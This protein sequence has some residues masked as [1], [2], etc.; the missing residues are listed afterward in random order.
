MES[1]K[2]KEFERLCIY[3]M[4]GAE[5]VGDA[6]MSRYGVQAS[7]QNNEWRPIESLPDFE[8]ILQGGRQFVFDCKVC[9]QASFPLDDD[10]FKRRQLKHLLRRAKFGG[11]T[12][13]LIH[14]NQRE[15]K[16]RTDEAR[17]V[18]FPLCGHHAGNFWVR[19][20][21]G[22][23]KRITRDACDEY[24]IDVDWT[25][26]AGKERPNL[27]AAILRLQLLIRKED[28]PF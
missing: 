20:D 28:A 15:M 1:L 26:P 17:T 24:G 8:G 5:R 21:A 7:L 2:A 25:G 23:E 13:L 6:T 9:S 3:A 10:K 12:F 18:V 19:V 27:L 16:T 4:E 14:W 22:A 11:I